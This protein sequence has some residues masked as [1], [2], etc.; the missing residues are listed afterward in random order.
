MLYLVEPIDEY[1]MQHLGDYDG[2]KFQ[3]L[4]KE[5]V[6]FGDEDEEIIKKRTKVYKEMFKPLTEYMKNLYTGKISKIT[7]SQRV[8]STPSVIVTSQ[9]GQS[10]NMERIMRA[11]TFA[12]TDRIKEMGSQKTMELN[13]R[14]PLII[15]LNTLIQDSPDEQSTIDLAWLLYDTALVS[16]GF[17]QEDLESYAE[18]MYRTMATSMNVPVTLELAPE[19]EVEDDVEDDVEATDEVDIDSM[20]SEL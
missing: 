9:Y 2:T 12:N 15:E 7:V 8:E 10:A 19:I 13:P 18:R 6:K 3:S 4:T 16:S 1:V 14:H 5:G 20:D 11:Q 17:Q